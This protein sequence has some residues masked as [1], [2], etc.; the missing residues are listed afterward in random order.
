MLPA[1]APSGICTGTA[2]A[3]SCSDWNGW[4]VALM[5]YSAAPIASSAISATKR[6]NQR[7]G[8]G[9]CGGSTGRP[10][11]PM[12]CAFAARLIGWRSATAVGRGAWSGAAR[13]R[14][15][16][17]DRR[18]APGGQLA[19]GTGPGSGRR[20]DGSGSGSA[21]ASGCGCAESARS[22]SAR[23]GGTLLRRPLALLGDR[24]ATRGPARAPRLAA[25]GGT[26]G[27]PR[28]SQR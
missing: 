27:R 14:R 21:A 20:V 19:A 11:R 10:G 17:R 16:R 5:A 4:N 1:S 28:P 22:R 8:L 2:P 25:G 26:A 7:L 15:A 18:R 13:T 6:R 3:C 23:R 12:R 24:P 9:D